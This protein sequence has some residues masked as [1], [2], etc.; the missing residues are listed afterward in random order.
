M[1]LLSGMLC[2]WIIHKKRL[3]D[4]KIL[5]ERELARHRIKQNIQVRRFEEEWE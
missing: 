1:A 4:L 5:H 2:L 3:R